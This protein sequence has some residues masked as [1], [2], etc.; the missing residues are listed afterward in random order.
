MGIGAGS[1]SIVRSFFA[2]SS[3]VVNRTATM[4]VVA[5]VQYAGFSLSPA[6]GSAISRSNYVNKLGDNFWFD[7]ET[8]PSFVL[9][10]VN[11][12]VAFVAYKLLMEPADVLETITTYQ[13]SIRVNATTTQRDSSAPSPAPGAE[14]QQIGLSFDRRTVLMLFGGFLLVNFLMRVVLG[15]MEALGSTLYDA[16]IEGEQNRTAAAISNNP[17]GMVSMSYLDSGYYYSILGVVGIVFLV[18]IHYVTKY[19]RDYFVLMLGLVAVLIGNLILIGTPSASSG[20]FSMPLSR[21]TVGAIIIWSVGYPLAQTVIVSMVSKV[22]GVH[23]S[24]GV[25]MSLFVLNIC[26][27]KFHYLT[28][29]SEEL[30]RQDRLEE[31]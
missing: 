19:L 18:S 12:A 11:L 16:V 28:N 24:Q 14:A 25:K 23:S 3:P 7:E 1:L 10:I 4:S 29:K 2:E 13:S 5:V 26:T 21:F 27:L 8:A 17:A 6:I 31:L 15:T 22:P 30:D 20:F 9:A